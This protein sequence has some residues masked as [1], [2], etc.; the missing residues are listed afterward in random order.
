MSQ[1]SHLLLSGIKPFG[2]M[3]KS[4]HRTFPFAT[5][6]SLSTE[7]RAKN[8]FRFRIHGIKIGFSLKFYRGSLRLLARHR[9]VT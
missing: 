3:N 2:T 9:S 4:S 5:F 8:S 7:A 1:V 6:L